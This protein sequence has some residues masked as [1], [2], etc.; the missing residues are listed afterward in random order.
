MTKFIFKIFVFF[1]LTFIIF[2]ID[3]PKA[4]SNIEPFIIRLEPNFL[5]QGGVQKVEIFKNSNCELVSVYFKSKKIPIKKLKDNQYVLILGASLNENPGAKKLKITYRCNQKE[6][7]YVKNIIVKRKQYPKEFLKVPKKMV[8]FPPKILKR[9]L[10]DQEVIKS[11]CK[12][13][14]KKIYWDFPFIW[15]VKKDISSPFGLKRY[16]NNEPRSPHSGVDLRAKENTPIRCPNNGQVALVRDCYLSGKT[17]IIDHGGGLYT[18]YAHLNR[19]D[20]KQGQFVKK[21]QIIGLSGCTGRITGPHLHFGLSLYGTRVD[22]VSFMK[23]FGTI[24]AN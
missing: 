21:G 12:K 3:L 5:F 18:L 23:L 9:V 8:S 22:P 17:V 4:F 24:N 2:F 13:M 7:V 10:S 15:P 16:F 6:E 19:V 14:G 11:I 1:I 20:V